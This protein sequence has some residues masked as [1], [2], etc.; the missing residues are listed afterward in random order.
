MNMSH[1]ILP[2][3]LEVS[4]VGTMLVD[5]TVT[6]YDLYMTQEDTTHRRDGT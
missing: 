1:A 3:T 4:A 2:R 6:T 5:Y